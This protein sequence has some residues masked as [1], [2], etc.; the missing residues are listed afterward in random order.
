MFVLWICR[1]L[2]QNFVTNDRILEKIVAHIGIVP[3]EPVLE[4]GPG[5][6]NLTKHLLEAGARVTA[7]E[8]DDRLQE[9][10]RKDFGDVSNVA[11]DFFASCRCFLAI[12]A[13][14]ASAPQ[15]LGRMSHGNVHFH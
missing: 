15:R 10:F 12:E 1:S 2:G 6:G 5:T 14:I 8:K 13:F 3:G 9:Q 11:V 7:L 4:L